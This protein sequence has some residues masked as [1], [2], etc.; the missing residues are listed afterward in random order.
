M[1]EQNV[2]KIRDLES[3]NEVQ[4]ITIEDFLI[5][6]STQGDPVTN[7]A[8][9]KEVVDAYNAS[10]AEED[11]DNEI[12]D[13]DDPEKTIKDPES[14]PG[15]ENDL[16]G[17]GEPDEKID[18]TPINAGNL[19]DFLD[20]NG[21]IEIVQECRTKGT[22]EIVACDDP[23]AYYKTNKLST[24]GFEG[25]PVVRRKGGFLSEAHFYKAGILKEIYYGK[26]SFLQY[27]ER[28]ESSNWFTASYAD[29]PDFQSTIMVTEEEESYWVFWME[30]GAQW[31]YWRPIPQYTYSNSFK[32]S[33]WL[34]Q[35]NLGWFFLM[36]DHYPYFYVVGS[37][38]GSEEEIGWVYLHPNNAGELY[39]FSI[40]EWRNVADLSIASSADNGSAN[41]TPITGG[42]PTVTSRPLEGIPS[43][44]PV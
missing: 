8:T 23:T 40:E 43:N 44:Q 14:T 16:D 37:L 11:P 13:P 10:I 17:D 31:V 7:K 34:W 39:I 9:I 36:M 42:F 28:L 33:F 21:G 38:P 20:P 41:P 19:E 26:G 18:I 22:K 5:V 1:A 35:Q 4:P 12:E 3:F 24:S 32:E 2:K 30:L 25:Y 15:I 29:N 6:A 27:F